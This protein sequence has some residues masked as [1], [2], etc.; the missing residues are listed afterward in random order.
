M[1]CVCGNVTS[2][3]VRLKA[4][5]R[6]SSSSWKSSNSSGATAAVRQHERV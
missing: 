3:G 4:K 1:V 2:N 6:S 5:R